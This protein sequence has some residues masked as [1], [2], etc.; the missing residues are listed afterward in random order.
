MI[1]PFD[2]MHAQ[3]VLRTHYSY[4]AIL[5]GDSERLAAKTAGLIAHDHFLLTQ[6][7][8]ADDTHVARKALSKRAYPTSNPS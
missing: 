1:Y 8:R 4:A 5:M 3:K 6:D 2:A 7:G